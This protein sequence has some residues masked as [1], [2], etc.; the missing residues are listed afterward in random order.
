MKWGE[1]GR[2]SMLQDI[3]NH[4]MTEVEAFSGELCKLGK[5]H[6]VPTPINEFLLHSIRYIERIKQ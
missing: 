5:L 3:E 2:P 6:N 1:N 4:R